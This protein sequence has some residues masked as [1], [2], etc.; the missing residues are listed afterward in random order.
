MI[1][2]EYYTQRQP[3]ANRA[4]ADFVSQICFGE[5]GQFECFSTMAVLDGGTLIAGV[6]YTDWQPDA[7]TIEMSAGAK[8]AR[9]FQAHIIR[10]AF[11]F[12]FDL[13]G[14]QMT[15]WSVSERNERMCSIA[16]RLGCDEVF[17]PRL[18]GRDEGVYLFT[19]TDDAWRESAIA[20]RGYPR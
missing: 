2:H 19:M 1:R 14:A 11:A 16:R 7:G 15:I 20:K 10:A 9:W 12:P 17:V 18:R 6:V 3:E 13:L 8:D 4:V 5:P